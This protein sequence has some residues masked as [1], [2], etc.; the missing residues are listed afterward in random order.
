MKPTDNK[1]SIIFNPTTAKEIII[2]IKDDRY[3]GENKIARITP[4]Q[5][6][7]LDWLMENEYISDDINLEYGYPEVEDLTK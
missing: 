1:E 2:H 6:K 4:E 7:L 5:Q 3:G